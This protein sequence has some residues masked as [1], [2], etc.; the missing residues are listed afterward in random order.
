VRLGKV[1]QVAYYDPFYTY[2]PS[3]VPCAP[4]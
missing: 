1:K 3:S 4:R 2:D